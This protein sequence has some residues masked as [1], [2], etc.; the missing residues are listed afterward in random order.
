MIKYLSYV[1]PLILKA[2]KTNPVK[3]LT[4]M[5]FAY[6][7]L[8]L[9]FCFFL[10]AIYIW[11]ASSFGTDIAFASLGLVTF[12]T[13]II[14]LISMKDKRVVQKP[15]PT[16]IKQDPLAKL[17]PDNIQSNPAIQ[18]LL[19]QIGESPVTATATAVT[20]GVLLSKEIFEETK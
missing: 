9:S 14:L 20:I 11:M 1:A 15:L 6:L 5:L 2:P 10:I 13:A 18:K 7:L 16:R 17:I 3:K 4:G 12:V 19:H 8:G